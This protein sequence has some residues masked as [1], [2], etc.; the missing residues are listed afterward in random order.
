MRCLMI[1][2]LMAGVTITAAIMMMLV[3]FVDQVS[4]FIVTIIR[5]AKNCYVSLDKLLAPVENVTVTN[6]GTTSVTVQW[7]VSVN[8]SGLG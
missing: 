1:A 5:H 7:D 3:W 6:V 8:L 2:I 4:D